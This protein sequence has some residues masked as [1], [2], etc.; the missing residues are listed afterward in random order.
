M[1]QHIVEAHR[2]IRNYMIANYYY[3]NKEKRILSKAPASPSPFGASIADD[4]V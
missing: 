3:Y 1:K 2:R 4:M